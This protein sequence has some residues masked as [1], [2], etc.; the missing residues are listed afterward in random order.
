MDNW[1]QLVV[2]AW[3]DP[4]LKERLLGN[5]GAVLGEHG[6]DVPEGVEVRVVENTD[7]VCYLT[8]PAKPAGDPSELSA[9]EL[10]AVVGGWV[11]SE[12]WDEVQHRKKARRRGK[13]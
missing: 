13:R 5:P 3:S 2:A 1:E 8:L 7:A 9:D 10:A 4:S 6:L 11:A 12:G